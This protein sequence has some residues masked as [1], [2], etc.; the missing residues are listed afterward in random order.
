MSRSF[1]NLRRT[2]FGVSCAIVFG[3]GTSEGFA[4][5][6]DPVPPPV[7]CLMGAPEGHEYCDD[8][9]WSTYGRPGFCSE[10]RGGCDC[11]WS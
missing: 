6:P 11:Y 4:T 5:L 3:F 8:Y 9:C 1:T 2:L 7:V 10:S